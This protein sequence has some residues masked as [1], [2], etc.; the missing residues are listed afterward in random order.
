MA[1]LEKIGPQPWRWVGRP[2]FKVRGDRVEKLLREIHI[3]RAKKFVES[4]PKNLAALGLAPGRQMEITV[5]TPGG[6]QTLFLGAKKDDAVYARK[7]T[8]APWCW[9]RPGW[10]ARSTRPWG[11]WGTAA[12]GPGPSPKSTRSSGAPPARPGRPEKSRPGSSP[13]RDQAA[14]QQPSAR[15]EMALWNFQ[16]L[17]GEPPPPK[18]TAPKGPPAFVLE[19]LD[20][21]GKP[22]FR[23]EEMGPG[24][25]DRLRS[26]TGGDKTEHGGAS[27]A[28][29]PV[30]GGDAPAAA[31]AKRRS[32]PQIR[33]R[34]A[35][36][37]GSKP[38]RRN[39]NFPVGA[40][41]GVHALRGTAATR[42]K[43]SGEHSCAYY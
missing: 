34:P 13:G 33:L 43:L 9:W 10:P 35:R 7:G 18:A 42:Q 4:A 5:V 11:T 19:L 24:A 16:K 8:G 31:A 26:S 21:A 39:D 14:T 1:D 38:A 20:Q 22:L 36:A 32:R 29:P 41:P 12:S 40:D 3:A 27:G 28:L 23:L 2:D 15:L 25:K 6:D 17:E 37:P 30:A